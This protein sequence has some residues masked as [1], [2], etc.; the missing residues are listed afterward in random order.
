MHIADAFAVRWPKDRR[1]IEKRLRWLEFD[2]CCAYQLSDVVFL[3]R[4]RPVSGRSDTR[5][6]AQP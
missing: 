4:S 2:E 6:P 5:T 3:L 1:H